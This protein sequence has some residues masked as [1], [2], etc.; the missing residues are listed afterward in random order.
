MIL[1]I[2]YVEQEDGWMASALSLPGCHTEGF[3]KEEAKA[4]LQGSLHFYFD[5]PEHIILVENEPENS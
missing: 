4:N 3:S 5:N 1:K 2:T